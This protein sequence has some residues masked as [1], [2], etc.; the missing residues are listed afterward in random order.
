MCVP[1]NVIY[2]GAVTRQDTG[3]TE[4]YTGLSEP[5]W[6]LKWNNHKS[7]FKTNTKANITATCLSKHVWKLKDKNIKYPINFEQLA[8]APSFNHVSN[9]FW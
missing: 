5:N 3:E 7:N 9:T 2:K 4:F 6:K 8:Q 1:G